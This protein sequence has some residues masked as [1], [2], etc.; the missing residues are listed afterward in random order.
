MALFG[1][2]TAF[3]ATAA[4]GAAAGTAF[5]TAAAAGGGLAAANANPMKD[6]PVNNCPDDSISCLRFSPPSVNTTTF[7]IAGSWDNNV[8]C[9]EI[10]A[11]GTSE[12]KT[13]QSMQGPVL[14]CC[15]HED[16]TKVFMASCDKQVKCWDLASNQ[17]IQVAEHA[18]PVKSI[19]W[20]QA[21]NY[22]ALMTG[23]WDKTLKF[24]DT[25]TP[26]PIMTIDLGER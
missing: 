1:Q 6:V 11:N 19:R 14:D 18:A 7:L 8:R 13:Q 20:I 15:W 12:P 17:T 22:Q 25:R 26:N 3:G 9:W 21:P 5:G 23:S 16:G 24:W 4:P 10:Q 2:S